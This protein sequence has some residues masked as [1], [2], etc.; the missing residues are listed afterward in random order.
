MIVSVLVRYNSQFAKKYEMDVKNQQT[1]IV[2]V[3]SSKRMV[4]SF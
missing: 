1:V 2:F 4:F 3:K